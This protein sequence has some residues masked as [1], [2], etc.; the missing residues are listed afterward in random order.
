[1]NWNALTA[2]APSGRPEAMLAWRAAEVLSRSEGG[3]VLLAHTMCKAPEERERESLHTFLQA[4]DQLRRQPALAQHHADTPHDL[5]AKAPALGSSAVGRALQA[6]A[7]VLKDSAAPDMAYAMSSPAAFARLLGVQLGESEETGD[8]V[9]ALLAPAASAGPHKLDRELML[10]HALMPAGVRAG[11]A[12]DAHSGAQALAALHHLRGAMRWS[13]LAGASAPPTDAAAV[14]AWRSAE[15]L[16]RTERGF[17]LLIENMH[18]APPAGD[19]R[20]AMR[21]FLQ[22]ADTLRETAP[23]L[24]AVAPG[25][26]RAILA[27]ARADQLGDTLASRVLK[28]SAARLDGAGPAAPAHAARATG[29]LFAWRQGA[30]EDGPR[31]TQKMMTARLHKFMRKAVP[32]AERSG[33]VAKLANAVGARTTPL[34]GLSMGVQGTHL[35]SVPKELEKYCAAFQHACVT[36][37]DDVRAMAAARDP[38]DE[39]ERGLVAGLLDDWAGLPRQKT[40]SGFSFAALAAAP[41]GSTLPDLAELPVTLDL[42]RHLA[43]HIKLPHDKVT[44][45]LQEARD[46]E[47]AAD[48]KPATMTRAAMA[49]VLNELVGKMQSGSRLKLSDGA[50]KGFSTV[51]ASAIVADAMS[52]AMV[53]GVRADLRYDFGRHATF[54]LARSGHG[55]EIF[56][57]TSKSHRALGGVGLKVGYDIKLGSEESKAGMKLRAG[58]GATAT[59]VDF[60]RSEGRGI[61]FRVERPMKESSR[62]S[63]DKD[64]GSVAYDDAG[65]VE[66]TRKLMA[67][68]L[69]AGADGLSEEA[70]WSKLASDFGE[71]VSVGWQDSKNTTNR[72]KMAVD[73]GAA[74]SGKAGGASLRA[75]ASISLSGE[76]TSSQQTKVKERGG[77]VNLLARKF[78]TGASLNLGATLGAGVGKGPKPKEEQAAPAPG[79]APGNKAQSGK[80]GAM[81]SGSLDLVSMQAVLGEQSQ[82]VKVSLPTQDGKLI[83]RAAYLDVEFASAEAWVGRIERERDLWVRTMT[84]E[85]VRDKGG[86][87]ADK[88]EIGPAMWAAFTEED[89]AEGTRQLDELIATARAEERPNFKYM[90]RQRIKPEAAAL[91]DSFSDIDRQGGSMFG[92]GDCKEQQRRLL[93]DAGSWLPQKLAIIEKMTEKDSFGVQSGLRMFGL[94]QAEGSRE[95]RSYNFQ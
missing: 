58:G 44:A 50:I 71:G 77:T 68:L 90:V 73:F 20:E 92:A 4:A 75:G 13:E 94:R 23:A 43:A 14:A 57:G 89:L 56:L 53:F 18:D 49:S 40:P 6:S 82:S 74:V 41:T 61:I 7:A 32:R 30:R 1:M 26:A 22:A 80:V 86:P 51:G 3:F 35:G 15:V 95:L 29:D 37:R 39:E 10:A 72:Q 12:P 64:W 62:A 19:K 11:A 85:Y 65:M 59:P 36:L 69:D 9:D 8:L 33:T 21:A 78:G 70:M 17:A 2:P 24:A 54:E 27:Q 46:L 66:T 91:Y 31:S 42:V 55:F 25:H 88:P 93:A 63:N 48:L 47:Q 67:F 83:N 60:E 38:L 81:S 16:A 5:L 79:A 28:H 76:N 34:R 84:S 52:G 45:A 87:G